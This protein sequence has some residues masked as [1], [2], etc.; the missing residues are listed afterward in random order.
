VPQTSAVVD[1]ARAAYL[2][3]RGD[4]STVVEDFELWLEARTELAR[5]KAD[6]FAVWSEVVALVGE[7]GTGTGTGTEE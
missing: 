7:S 5:R 2:A 3:G 4:F 6:R 1:A